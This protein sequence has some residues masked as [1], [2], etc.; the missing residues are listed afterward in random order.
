MRMYIKPGD[1]SYLN[2]HWG[3]GAAAQFWESIPVL[4]RATENDENPHQCLTYE[5]AVNMLW[6]TARAGHIHGPR[7]G[8]TIIDAVEMLETTLKWWTKHCNK[9]PENIEH[10]VTS[11][12]FYL[13]EAHNI[14]PYPEPSPFPFVYGSPIEEGY[15][16]EK[17][18]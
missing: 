9:R 14:L 7:C 10:V 8:L 3:D 12:M 6:F 5:E 1:E 17:T 4:V 11:Y 2:Y 13:G 18:D 15:Y 16:A